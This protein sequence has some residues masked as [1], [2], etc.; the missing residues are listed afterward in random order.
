LCIVSSV[1]SE[2]TN[3]EA[4][5]TGHIFDDRGNRVWYEFNGTERHSSI[6]PSGAVTSDV[7]GRVVT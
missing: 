5:L 1:Q 3:S 4:L 2:R 6:L 7:R